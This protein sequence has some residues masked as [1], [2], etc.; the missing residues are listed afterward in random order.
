MCFTFKKRISRQ[1]IPFYRFLQ[2]G[3]SAGIRSLQTSIV[4]KLCQMPGNGLKRNYPINWELFFFPTFLG[5]FR[6]QHGP[7]GYC[8]QVQGTAV[9][10]G[11]CNKQSLAQKWQMMSTIT[12]QGQIKHLQSNLC[13]AIK[14]STD[15]SIVVHSCTDS[16]Y[17]NMRLWGCHFA[18]HN[19]DSKWDDMDWP[20]LK[21][22]HT[23]EC[24]SV[25][26]SNRVLAKT[27]TPHGRNNE[28]NI[29]VH[30]K[31]LM[32]VCAKAGL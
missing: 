21:M 10:V 4:I 20:S 14:S 30:E 16:A 1:R 19:K 17:Q 12:Y 9:K 27:C 6:I 15:K 29:V 7:L 13:L 5:T 26:S 28:Q 11:T 2:D 24:L 25:T 8:L 3:A 23:G 31:K 32:S 22:I 18:K